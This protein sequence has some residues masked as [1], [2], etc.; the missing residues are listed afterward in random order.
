MSGDRPIIC[1]RCTSNCT[2]TIEGFCKCRFCRWEGAIAATSEFDRRPPTESCIAITDVVL[3]VA[4]PHLQETG[5][6][7]WIRCTLNGALV[8]D[9][10]SLRRTADGRQAISFPARTDANGRQHFF[11][12]PTGDGMRREIEARILGPLRERT[13]VEDG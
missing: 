13:E 12:R 9:G 6:R 10:I 11:I 1:P 7:G 4:P 8:L 5:L 3:T 2:K